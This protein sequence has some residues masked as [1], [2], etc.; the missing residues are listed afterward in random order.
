MDQLYRS[1]I[2]VD[3]EA[4]AGL[5]T[6]QLGDYLAMVSLS[7]VDPEAETG[8]YDTILNLF[9]NPSA[10]PEMTAWDR[11]YLTAL[12]SSPSRRRSAGAQA[13]AVAAIM[14]ADAEKT[15]NE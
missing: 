6:T 4:V 5:S 7:Q 9:D 10:V 15:E 13:T 3:I 14:N 1:I 2:I 11:A 12:Y 8:A